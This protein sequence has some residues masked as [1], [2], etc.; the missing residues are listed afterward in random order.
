MSPT[1]STEVLR[2][3]A[4][5]L[6]AENGIDALTLSQV[7]ERSG[8]SRA[9]TYREFGDKDGLLGAVA[10]HQIAAMIT[11]SFREVALDSDPV[12]IVP[13]VIMNALHF[14]RNHAAFTYVRDH[15]PHWLLHAVLVIGQARMNLVETV[16]VTVAPIM[17]TANMS[18][19]ALPA[20]QAAEF[21]VRTVLSHSV[22]EASALTDCQVAEAVTRA[23]IAHQT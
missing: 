12:E 18:R 20:L 19:L 10:R 13:T 16:A 9:T 22:I 8:V 3:A 11:E 4:L 23:I 2:A 1:R 5:D 14:L 7:A 15:E 21:V 17:S 6:I